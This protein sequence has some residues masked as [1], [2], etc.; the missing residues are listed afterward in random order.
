MITERGF[1][2]R[3]LEGG[4]RSIHL[5]KITEDGALITMR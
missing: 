5:L 4:F 1:M 3:R 2:T